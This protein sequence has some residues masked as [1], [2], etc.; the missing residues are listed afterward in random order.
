[1]V[2]HY[3]T[4]KLIRRGPLPVRPK[5]FPRRAYAVLATVSRSYSPHQGRFPRVTHPSA[6]KDTPEGAPSFD[7]HVLGT[8]PAFVLSQDQTLKFALKLETSLAR[9]CYVFGHAQRISWDPLTVLGRD[10]FSK[11]SRSESMRDLTC[12]A[13]AVRDAPPPTHLFHLFTCQTTPVRSPNPA[14]GGE[15]RL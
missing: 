5:P 6:T 1:M 14:T 11:E 10:P 7:L 3:P 2:G 15:R 9:T 13:R 8:P 12:H 4:N